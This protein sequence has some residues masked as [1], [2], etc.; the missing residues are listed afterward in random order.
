MS[1][2]R[3]FALNRP[4]LFG[5]ILIVLYA[6]LGTITYPVH[7]LF[8]ENDL[9]QLYG[10]TLSKLIIFGIF[11]TILW[12]FGWIQFS[13]INS[14]G[15]PMTWL[16]VALILVYKILVE[17]YAFTGNLS[18][19]LSNPTLAIA[20]LIYGLPNSLVEETMF[21]GLVLVAMISAWGSSKS[22]QIKAIL[23]SSLF[24]GLMHLFNIIARPIGIVV[25]QAFI[26]TLPGILYSAIVLARK[27][28]WPAI[29]IHWLTNSAVNIKLIGYNNYQE[30]LTMWGIFGLAFIP[31]IAYSA[32][33]IWKLPES[34][35]YEQDQTAYR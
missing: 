27:S 32:Y 5:L 9:G 18:F 15:E 16:I 24:F 19:P 17:L 1:K 20:N 13:K 21:R 30:N 26:I 11:L 34:Y 7:F 23:L 3:N 14:P 6:L 28:L 33:L 29:I 12:K 8:P 22:G 31:L 2:F 25:F 35:Q 4:F 10:D